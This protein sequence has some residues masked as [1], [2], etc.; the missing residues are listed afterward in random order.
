MRDKDVICF[1]DIL[2]VEV[3]WQH[4]WTIKP[5]VKE[6]DQAIGT[7]SISSR[8]YSVGQSCLWEDGREKVSTKPL[9]SRRHVEAA[10]SEE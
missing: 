3:L 2:Y 10:F 7:Q 1:D 4:I 9:K 6:D 5:G 8:T